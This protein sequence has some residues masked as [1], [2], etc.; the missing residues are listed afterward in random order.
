MQRLFLKVSILANA[1]EFVEEDGAFF[2]CF[3]FVGMVLA[4]F[5][6]QKITHLR[7]FRLTLRLQTLD[8]VG[9]LHVL[10]FCCAELVPKIISRLLRALLLLLQHIKFK[11]YVSQ[12]GLSAI[13]LHFEVKNAS[14]GS[15]SI[16]LAQLI[17]FF[18][19]IYRGRLHCLDLRQQEVYHPVLVLK[20]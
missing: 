20:P 13:I 16:F 14:L 2:F 1:H 8:K 4:Q 5:G 11:Q 6:L 17:R 18:V 12:G 10:F 19:A 15:L 9:H 3:H 7:K